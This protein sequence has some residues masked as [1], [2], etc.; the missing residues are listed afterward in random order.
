MSDKKVISPDGEIVEVSEANAFDLVRLNGYQDYD[1]DE[2]VSV[3]K[4]VEEAPI[5]KAKAEPAP[6]R[7]RPAKA[8]EA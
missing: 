5:E 1:P 4:P 3:V 8:S 2:A 6:K 7:G